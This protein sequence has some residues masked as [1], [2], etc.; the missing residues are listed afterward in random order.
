MRPR[1]HLRHGAV[2][3]DDAEGARGV[4]ECL[5]GPREE[6]L[7]RHHRRL[8][9]HDGLPAAGAHGRQHPRLHV[10]DGPVPDGFRR[11]RQV[12]QDLN[13]DSERRNLEAAKGHPAQPVRLRCRRHALH[14]QGLP[15]HPGLRRRREG[16]AGGRRVCHPRHDRDGQG[17]LERRPVHQGDRLGVHRAAAVRRR[18]ARPV[19]PPGVGRDHV[20]R[21]FHLLQERQPQVRL[22]PMAGGLGR[23]SGRVHVGTELE[24]GGAESAPQR[25]RRFSGR[26][27]GTGAGPVR[28]GPPDAPRPRTAFFV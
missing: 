3:E 7:L 17:H 28:D 1:P 6:R 12:R 2:R 13:P 23:H 15:K 19:Q 4:H 26:R 11:F 22:E 16:R 18:A 20:R 5:Q 9:V 27:R 25:V 14:H 24:P 10:L 21:L 8:R